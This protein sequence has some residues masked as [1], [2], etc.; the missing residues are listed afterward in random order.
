[1]RLKLGNC[2]KFCLPWGKDC[3][4]LEPWESEPALG[5]QEREEK[6]QSEEDGQWGGQ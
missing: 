3:S 1:M 2:S 5:T 4:P 6:N